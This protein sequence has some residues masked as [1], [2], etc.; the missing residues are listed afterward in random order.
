M[1]ADQIQR[2]LFRDHAV[3]GQV[4]HLNQAWRSMLK[5]RHYPTPLVKMLGELTA[6][7]C[8][9]ANGL[10]HPGRIILQVQ[11]T[12]PVNLLVVEVSHELQ[13]KGMAKTN[14]PIT[15]Q[16]SA[17]A[18]LGDG[19][20]L[21]TLENPQ[22]DHLYQSYVP[23]EGDDLVSSLQGFLTQ[24][25]QLDSR[26]WV[27]VSEQA[28]GG[29]YLQKMPQ[30][31]GHDADAWDRVTHLAGTVKAEELESLENETLLTRLFHEEQVELFEAR[32]LEHHCPQ[33]RQRVA[34]MVQSLGEEE[35]RSILAEHGEIVV[36]NDMCNYH[37]RFSEQDIDQLFQPQ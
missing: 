12:G 5:D 28:I 24:S 7:A 19:Q 17:D 33:D 22:T 3:R 32:P 1:S 4:I 15:D 30:T 11:G 35:A 8:L 29:L 2:F 34:T 31:D 18:L 21:V 13:L 6:F 26:F 14:A 20:I 25:E 10:K 36:F 27:S 16:Q 23:R 9:L 37:E